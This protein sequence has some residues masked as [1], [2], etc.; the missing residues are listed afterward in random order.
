MAELV[1]LNPAAA[2]LAPGAEPRAP[3]YPAQG[4]I[5]FAYYGGDVA[6][7]LVRG[8]AGRGPGT[9]AGS[10]LRAACLLVLLA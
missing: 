2:W 9:L 5:P 3:C 7:G 1:Q 8:S 6:F 10:E 4:N